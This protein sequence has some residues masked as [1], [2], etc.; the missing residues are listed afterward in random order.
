MTSHTVPLDYSF[1]KKD[2]FCGKSMLDVYL[3]E[4]AGQ[5]MKRKLCVVFI[6]PHEKN[7]IKGYYTLSNHCTPKEIV[8]EKII[9]KMPP[10]YSH[11]PTTLMGRLAVDQK[12]MKQGIGE[13]L[14]LDALK[15]SYHISISSLGS[16]AVVVDPLDEES[17][18]FY[19]KYG[20]HQLQSSNKMFLLMNDITKLF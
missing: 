12:F 16:F 6:L 13:L 10:S 11:L 7:L 14:L 19:S 5:D 2:F 4:Q 3:H 1:N 15:R 20:F 17:K 18:R 8:P 9:K